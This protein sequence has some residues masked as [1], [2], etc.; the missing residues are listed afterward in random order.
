MNY[1]P[2]DLVCKKLAMSPWQSYQFFRGN[3]LHLVRE[4]D[5]IAET[6]RARV[7]ISDTFKFVPDLLTADEISTLTGV[8]VAKF[9][10]WT[11][12]TKNPVPHIRFN[13]HTTRFVKSIVD[14]WLDRN[15]K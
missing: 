12:R 10:L 6:N 3:A 5:V 9:K 11:R 4:D 14:D 1:L 15:S 13:K 2:R 7:A 8:P